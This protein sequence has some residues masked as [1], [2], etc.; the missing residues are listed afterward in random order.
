MGLVDIHSVAA[1]RSRSVMRRGLANQTCGRE[2]TISPQEPISYAE[3]SQSK[4]RA[5]QAAENATA[6]DVAEVLTAILKNLDDD[7]LPA[8]KFWNSISSF[9]AS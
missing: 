7:D 2:V 6:E 9:I 1:E 4:I 8:S 5:R 3:R